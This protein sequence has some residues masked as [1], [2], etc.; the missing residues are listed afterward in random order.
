MKYHRQTINIDGVEWHIQADGSRTARIG[1]LAFR[2]MRDE[3][4]DG[5][6]ELQRVRLF[7]L[8]YCDFEKLTS[9]ARYEALRTTA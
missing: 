6:W 3:H 8:A 4:S 1:D 7:T 5:L 2:A 9:A